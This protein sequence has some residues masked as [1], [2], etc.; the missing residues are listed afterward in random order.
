VA[1][2]APVGFLNRLH[3]GGR[4][5]VFPLMS[6]LAIGVAAFLLAKSALTYP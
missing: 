2:P 4:A 6:G 1:C 5:V 3:A